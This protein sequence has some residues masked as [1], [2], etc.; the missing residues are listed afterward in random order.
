MRILTSGESHGPALVAIIEGLPS[1][2]PVWPEKIDEQLRRRQLGAG[3]GYRQVIEKDHVEILSGV[4]HGRTL[5]SPVALRIENRDWKNW[6][7]TMSAGEGRSDRAVTL[8]RPGHADLAGAIKY[9]RRDARDILERAS[10]R[11]TAARVAAGALVG[12]L[13][14][15][16]GIRVASCV[17]AIGSVK[18]PVVPDFDQCPGLE[19]ELP[20]PDEA[21]RR[22]AAAEIKRAKAS[23]DTLGGRIL[24]IAR[25]V[26]PGLGSHVQWDRRLDSRLSAWLMS[27]PSAKGVLLGDIEEAAEGLGSDFHD[28]IEYEPKRGFIRPTNH[29]GGLEGGMTN[30][31]DLRIQVLLKPLPTLMHPLPSADLLTKKTAKARVERSDVC[32]VVP[33]AVIGEA[34]TSLCLAEACL[35]KFGGDSLLEF[36]RNVDG[37]LRQV[38]DF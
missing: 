7:D 38:K 8:P 35:E 11:E 3:R 37:Y 10:A 36:K 23:G 2:L 20:F 18:S 14:E 5:G 32:A 1:G 27:L 21:S 13:L 31:Q 29:A 4:R 9:D 16:P 30:G 34:L 19:P 22:L 25:G 6:M 15:V 26:P 33:A 24:V 12:P 17:L 28:P